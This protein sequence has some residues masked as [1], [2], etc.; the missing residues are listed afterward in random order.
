M[1]QPEEAAQVQALLQPLSPDLATQYFCKACCCAL[2]IKQSSFSFVLAAMPERCLCRRFLLQLAGAHDNALEVRLDIPGKGK[3]V[4]SLKVYRIMPPIMGSC[5]LHG[6][7]LLTGSWWCTPILDH[8]QHMARLQ[9]SLHLI[10]VPEGLDSCTQDMPSWRWALRLHVQDFVPEEL[11]F[12]EPPLVGAQ[13]TVNCADALV[14]SRCFTM[15]GSIEKQLAHR[16]L[17]RAGE[18]E[19]CKYCLHA[20][21]L[22]APLTCDSSASGR[23]QQALHTI[24]PHV[25]AHAEWGAAHAGGTAVNPDYLR[26]LW[27]ESIRLP[28]SERFPMPALVGCR[29]CSLHMHALSHP[30]H[31]SDSARLAPPQSRHRPSSHAGVLPGRL[32]GCGIL[33]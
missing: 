19:Y 17:A 30:C 3:G 28:Y 23:S 27:L 26:S 6:K 8:K 31:R 1:L 12:R 24:V 9:C 5:A 11:V 33:Q 20:L 18:G 7:R 16:L 21:N 29:Q 32:H 25:S 14:C 4:I 15:V 10:H 22:P 13:H 2:S